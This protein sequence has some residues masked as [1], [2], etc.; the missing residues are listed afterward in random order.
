M[1]YNEGG[2][3]I[4]ENGKRKTQT[5]AA[6]IGAQSLICNS[7]IQK[8]L[9]I[10]FLVYSQSSHLETTPDLHYTEPPSSLHLSPCS[11]SSHTF[12]C[13]NIMSN[14]HPTRVCNSYMIYTSH[15][16]PYSEKCM[17]SSEPEDFGWKLWPCTYT[18]LTETKVPRMLCSL[19][20]AMN[21]L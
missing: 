8:F 18:A 15:Y 20:S 1:L 17:H 19:E 10:T 13:R 3:N 21:L 11:E 2:Y 16:F 7:K 5:Y 6:Y 4:F 14:I 12:C 9:N